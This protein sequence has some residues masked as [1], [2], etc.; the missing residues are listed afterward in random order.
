M[1]QIRQAIELNVPVY[2]AYNQWTQF[3]KFP[4]FMDGVQEV[5]QLDDAHLHWRAIRNGKEIEWDSE[6]IEQVPDQLITWR[7]MDGP[8]N[9]GSI[10]FKPLKDNSS[11]VELVME[12]APKEAATSATAQSVI[13]QRIEQDLS[14]FKQMLESQGKESGA[15]RGEI[16]QAHTTRHAEP[17]S[18]ARSSH[19]PWLPN[20][21]Q[22]W[23]EPVGMMRKMSD[24]MDQLFERVLGRPMAF[25]FGHGGMANKW[26]P[27]I[28]IT[29]QDKQLIIYAALPGVKKENIKIEIREGKLILEGERKEAAQQQISNQGYRK[30]ELSAGAFYRMIP[31]PEGVDENQSTASLQ[32]G[33]LEIRL[34]LKEQPQQ[35]GKQ[36]E[37]KS[38]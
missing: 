26:I 38:P 7:D 21:L 28:D 12:I 4:K 19:Q 30:V 32:D 6:I 13:Q 9:Q 25:R 33:I 22:G 36:L 11:T 17:V 29:Q 23:E 3:E 24:E 16:H 37:I 34:L 20:L 27:Q 5:K 8:G 10:Y 1:T 2:T 15:W 18:M 14:R 31:L 35:Q